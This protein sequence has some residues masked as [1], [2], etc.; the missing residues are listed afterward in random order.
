MMA[1]YDIELRACVKG[2]EDIIEKINLASEL[3]SK[4][5]EIIEEITWNGVSPAVKKE[6]H[7]VE[8]HGA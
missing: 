1:T 3:L 5:R 7:E 6:A 4:A 2:T 8:A